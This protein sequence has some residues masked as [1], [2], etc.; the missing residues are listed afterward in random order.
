LKL[1]GL[2]YGNQNKH[3]GPIVYYISGGR[4][5]LRGERVNF[6]NMA[7][8]WGVVFILLKGKEGG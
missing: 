5:F 7:I 2:L 4:W 1:S 6:L 8:L 3:K